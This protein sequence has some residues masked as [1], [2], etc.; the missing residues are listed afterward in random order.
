VGAI[1]ATVS[2]FIVLRFLPHSLTPAGAMTGP[3]ESLEEAAELGLAGVPPIFADTESDE[4]RS[5]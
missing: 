2:A 1:L 3:V 5:A 4:Q